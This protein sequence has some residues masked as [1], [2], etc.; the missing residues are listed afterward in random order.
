MQNRDASKMVGTRSRKRVSTTVLMWALFAVAA[1]W[2]ALQSC[3]NDALADA[4]EVVL[5]AMVAVGVISRNMQH[6]RASDPFERSLPVDD[7]ASDVDHAAANSRSNTLALLSGSIAH[8]VSQPLAA[9]VTGTDAGLRWLNKDKPDLDE[10]R[11]A[12]LRVREDAVRAAE[13]VRAL[14]SATKLEQPRLQ[15][16]RV[17][18]LLRETLYALN[19]SL[20]RANVRVHASIPSGLATVADKGQIQQLVRNL[21]N[22]AVDAMSHNVEPKVLWL[23]AEHSEAAVTVR[24]MDNGCGIAHGDCERIFEPFV[25]TKVHGMGLGLHIC[26]SVAEAHGGRL[27]CAARAEGGAIFTFTLPY[28]REVLGQAV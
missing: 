26:R 27:W 5:F 28:R 24:V 15:P 11:A 4:P 12:F 16:L 10:A 25:S 21:V 3:I 14:R 22:N 2:I 8:E 13:I 19:P 17:D 18:T 6:R 7:G 9:I 1:V 20:T 23:E